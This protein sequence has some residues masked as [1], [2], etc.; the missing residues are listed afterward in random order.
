MLA[1]SLVLLDREQAWMAVCN[2][3]RWCIRLDVTDR[4]WLARSPVFTSKEA[5][6][7]VNLH[8]Q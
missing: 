4:K 5:D 8:Q 1:R 6:L 2:A 7:M 3:G